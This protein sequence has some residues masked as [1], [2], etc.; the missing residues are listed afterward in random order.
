M[1]ID[2]KNRRS[3][4]STFTD[5]MNNVY[6]DRK[7]DLKQK[8][9]QNLIKTYLIEGHVGKNKVVN[10]ND[11]NKFFV[12]NST[13]NN[14]DLDIYETDEEN[15]FKLIIDE[16]ELFL[17]AVSNQRFWQIHTAFD[18]ESSDEKMRKLLRT[19]PS[20]DRVWLT[21]N[22]LQ[23]TKKYSMWRGISLKHNEIAE[24]GKEDYEAES[25]NFSV[26]GSTQKKV[27]DFIS[28]LKNNDEFNY[29]T[30]ISRIS[31][32]SSSGDGENKVLDDIKYNGK[33]STRGKS[34]NRHLW[35][36]NKIYD[37][38]QEK[39]DAIENDF[40][41]NYSDNSLEGLPINIEFERNDLNAKYIVETIF[42]SKKPFKL[43]GYPKKLSDNYY[44]IFA[45]DLH[46]GNQGKKINFEVTSDFIT[47]YLPKGNCGNTIAR[48]ICNIQIHLDSM[49]N[50]WGGDGKNDLF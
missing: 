40:A 49:I 17:D 20:L 47:V 7:K 43:W 31:V 38:Y 46:N 13:N 41:I 32:S 16:V 39:V 28:L 24:K 34:F 19:F 27:N 33:F 14:F 22:L 2:S 15:F 45:V 10:H 37:E 4:F 3:L 9:G 11:I 30:G 48:L 1:E 25:I 36:I 50:I 12:D 23:K 35:L 18:S 8:L 26:N 6:E 21:K 29:S 42:S 5:I 44:K